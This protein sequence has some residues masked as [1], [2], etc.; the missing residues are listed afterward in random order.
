[1]AGLGVEPAGTQVGDKTLGLREAFM[2]LH[3]H[4]GRR[5]V[6]DAVDERRLGLVEPARH[7]RRPP[8]GIALANLHGAK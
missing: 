4:P 8:V 7:L 5:R 1:M 3:L 6:A 2:L